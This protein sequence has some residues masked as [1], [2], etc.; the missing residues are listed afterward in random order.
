MTDYGLW[1]LVVFNSL[2]FIGLVVSFFRSKTKRD[3]L[4][5]GGFSA[6]IVALFT[7]MYG[8]PGGHP[9][10]PRTHDQPLAERSE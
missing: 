1:A 5:L 9:P 6:F 3:W 2:L 8:Y 10:T 7:E 4:A